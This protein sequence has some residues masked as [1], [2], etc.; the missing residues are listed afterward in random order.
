MNLKV[1]TRI[2]RLAFALL[3]GQLRGSAQSDAAIAQ[4]LSHIVRIAAQAYHNHVGEPIDPS[5]I[6]AEPAM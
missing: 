1:A 3:R 4:T 6:K 2:A 5:L